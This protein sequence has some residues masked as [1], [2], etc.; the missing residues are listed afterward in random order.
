MGNAINFKTVTFFKRV[1]PVVTPVFASLPQSNLATEENV[2]HFALVVA[3]GLSDGFR[4][5]RV[6]AF[7]LR[8]RVGVFCIFNISGRARPILRSVMCVTQCDCRYKPGPYRST[9]VQ[10]KKTVTVYS[11]CKQLPPFG[12]VRQYI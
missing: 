6:I 9:A 4:T 10:I 1:A 11:S 7:A 8:V 2:S 12:V 5:C 3:C